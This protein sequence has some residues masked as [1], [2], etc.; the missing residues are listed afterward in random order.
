MEALGD[1][2]QKR[3]AEKK[4]SVTGDSIAHARPTTTG[5]GLTLKND[6]FAPPLRADLP[7]LKPSGS[8]SG[9]A[10]LLMPGAYRCCTSDNWCR[11][12]PASSAR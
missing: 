6:R 5:G 4:T 11:S 12:P 7:G 1:G 10:R 8:A 2:H 3:H 9:L